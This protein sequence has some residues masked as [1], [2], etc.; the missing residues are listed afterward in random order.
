VKA[1]QVKYLPATAF[2][3]ARI[4]AWTEGGNSLTQSWNHELQDYDNA[5]ECAYSLA[6]RLKWDGKYV[7]GCLPNGNWAFVL[8][9]K[10]RKLWVVIGGM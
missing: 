3:D 8:A 5:C 2:K 4:K 10:N 1:I 9:E 7:G 6:L